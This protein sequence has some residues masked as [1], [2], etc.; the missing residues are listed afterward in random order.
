MQKN[1]LCFQVITT[2][3]IGLSLGHFGLDTASATP[4]DRLDRVEQHMPTSTAR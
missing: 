2:I 1:P 4:A 3:V